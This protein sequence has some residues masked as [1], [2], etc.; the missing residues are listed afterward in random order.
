M[1]INLTPEQEA[2]VNAE[3]KAGNFRTAEEVIAEAL[4][5]LREKERSSASGAANGGQ[6]NAV[7]EMLRFV[8]ANRVNLEGISVKELIREGHRL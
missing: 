3:L 4:Q 2:I 1:K 5:A 8:E 6:R 7:A